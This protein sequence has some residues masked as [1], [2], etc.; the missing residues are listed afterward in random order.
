MASPR[1]NLGRKPW[2]NPHSLLPRRA[3]SSRPA[4]RGQGADCLAFAAGCKNPILSD[5]P[6][7]DVGADEGARTGRRRRHPARQEQGSAGALRRGLRAIQHGVRAGLM[8]GEVATTAWRGAS[9]ARSSIGARSG[10]FGAAS[11][12]NRQGLHVWRCMECHRGSEL[13]VC[14]TIAETRRIARTDIHRA[15]FAR[16]PPRRRLSR[17]TTRRDEIDDT[18]PIARRRMSIPL[19]R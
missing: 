11:R 5:D 12:A 14:S 3:S 18:G 7:D 4:G 16:P 19:V 8:A 17:A 15:S 9:R 2:R 6:R 13:S 10:D 1:H